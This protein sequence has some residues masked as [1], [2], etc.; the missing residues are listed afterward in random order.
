MRKLLSALVAAFGLLLSQAASAQDQTSYNFIYYDPWTTGQWLVDL[1]DSGNYMT[2][3]Y[4]ACIS[5]TEEIAAGGSESACSRATDYYGAPVSDWV[6][7]AGGGDDT[8]NGNGSTGWAAN[9]LNVADRF[10]YNPNQW[11][12]CIESYFGQQLIAPF[13]LWQAMQSNQ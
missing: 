6:C 3:S 13:S 11:A 5:L 9:F 10:T 1:T 8:L 4:V 7:S 12:S 2:Y